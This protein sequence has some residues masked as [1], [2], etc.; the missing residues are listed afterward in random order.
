VHTALMSAPL[1]SSLAI[2]NSSKLTSSDNVIL[3]A[4]DND[5]H[6]FSGCPASFSFPRVTRAQTLNLPQRPAHVVRSM[7]RQAGSQN[8][9]TMSQSPTALERPNPTA[10]EDVPQARL[11]EGPQ[12][13]AMLRHALPKTRT[14][15]GTCANAT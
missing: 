4:H 7:P 14:Q 10:H 9:T 6:N 11:K 5:N 13:N 3:P 2:T 1:S 8:T 12:A 15:E